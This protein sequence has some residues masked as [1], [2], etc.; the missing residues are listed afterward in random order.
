[1][2]IQDTATKAIDAALGASDLAMEKAKA[3]AE[4]LREFD[5]KEFWAKAQKEVAKNFDQLAVRG[6]SLRK[7]IKD[8]APAKRATAQTRQARRQ[9]KAAATSIRKAVTA[10]VDATK[11]AAKKVG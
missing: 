2:T 3:F 7:N 8:S 1:M 4:D 5:A 6:A 10:D 11:S 9:V